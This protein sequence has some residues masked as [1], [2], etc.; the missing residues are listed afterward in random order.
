MFLDEFWGR[1]VGGWE[2]KWGGIQEKDTG[3]KA[4]SDHVLTQTY[5][6]CIAVLIAATSIFFI[7]IIASNARLAVSPPVAKAS[8]STRGVICQ[9]IPHLSLHQP[10]SLS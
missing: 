7:V 4:R 5:Q 10:H 3:Q 6:L 2:S 1:I 9:L 8:V